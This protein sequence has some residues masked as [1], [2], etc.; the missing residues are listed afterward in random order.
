MKAAAFSAPG[1]PE[2][3]E[4]VEVDTPEAGPGQVRVRVKAAGVQ[5]VDLAVREGWTPPGATLVYPQVIGNEFAGVVDQ[6]GA[7][8]TGYSVGDEVLGFSTLG[9]YA[10]Y[11]AVPA[12][13]VTHKPANVPWEVAA[14]LSGAGQAAHTAVEV[15]GVKDGETFLVHAAAGAVGTVAVQLARMIGATVIGTAS[16]ANHDYLRSLGAIPVTYGEGLVERVRA[17]APDGVDVSLDAAGADGL[18]AAV[19]LV[20]DKDRVGT[21]VAFEIYQELGVRWLGSKRS[22]E[23]LATLARLVDEGALKIQVRRTYPLEQAADAHREVGTGHGRG[24]VV[25]SIG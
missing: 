2:V 8:V 9:A 24:K 6:V 1:G 23:R 3:L 18:R 15:L 7:D 20:A 13:Q 12:D 22:P 19:E 10:E 11:V 25:L 5:P 16:E 17:L 4:L 21:M 14:G